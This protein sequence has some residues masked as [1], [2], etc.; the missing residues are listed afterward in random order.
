MSLLKKRS[1]EYRSSIDS[2]GKTHVI[3]FDVSSVPA[4]NLV[5]LT[6]FYRDFKTVIAR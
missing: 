5:N 4:S 6:A 2:V 3:E 1:W